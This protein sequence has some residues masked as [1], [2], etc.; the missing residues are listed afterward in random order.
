MVNIDPAGGQ[1]LNCNTA[2]KRG[3]MWKRRG[4]LITP[5]GYADTLVHEYG[6]QIIIKAPNEE[7][8]SA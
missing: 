6:H 7:A 5:E 8:L 1:S 2:Q 3:K 4:L